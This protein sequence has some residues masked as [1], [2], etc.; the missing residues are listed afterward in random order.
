MPFNRPSLKDHIER[1]K[2]GLE[3]ELTGYSETLRFKFSKILAYVIGGA[4]HLIYGW[5]EQIV[6]MFF[7]NTAVG[8]FLLNRAATYKIYPR[9]ATYFVGYAIFKGINGVGVSAN[10]TLNAENGIQYLTKES[11]F[12]SA[13]QVLIKVEAL[14]AGTIAN[15]VAGQKLTLVSPINGVENEA[16][17]SASGLIQALDQEDPELLRTRLLQRIQNPPAGGNDADYERWALE[18]GAT[19]AWPYPNYMG[20]GRVGITFVYDTRDDIIPT[21][22][23]VE[24]LRLYVEARR[25]MCATTIAFAPIPKSLPFQIQVSPDS[26]EVREAI[27]AEL[28]DMISRDAKP[29]GKILLSRIREAISVAAGEDDNTLLAPVADDQAVNGEIHIFGGITWI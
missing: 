8:E 22:S 14:T 15:L 7:A 11:G 5:L 16:E 1:I 19:R 24:A 12:I 21:E 18:F 4:I 29:N 10:K 23:E 20:S 13:G 3:K 6:L 27:E 26:P 25:P 28:R 9:P 2:S 17:I